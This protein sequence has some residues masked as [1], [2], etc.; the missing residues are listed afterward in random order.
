TLACFSPLV[1]PT[2]LKPRELLEVPVPHVPFLCMS[3]PVL[4]IDTPRTPLPAPFS[5]ALAEQLTHA[6]RTSD[7]KGKVEIGKSWG[8]G[9]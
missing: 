2:E 4:H 5:D 3:M 1:V 8:N 6:V 7:E 9:S